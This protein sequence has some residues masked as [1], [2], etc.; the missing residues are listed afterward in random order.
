MA[1]G[2]TNPCKA[3]KIQLWVG[4]PK[5]LGEPTTPVWVKFLF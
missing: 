1:I 5:P 2:N 3:S 4:G